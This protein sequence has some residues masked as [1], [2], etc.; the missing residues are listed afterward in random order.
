M[1]PS[2]H[3]AQSRDIRGLYDLWAPRYPP[4]PHN[5]LMRAEQRAMLAL[6]PDVTGRRVLDLACGS[7]RYAHLM[8][9]AGAGHVTAVDFSP[10]MLSRCRA[11]SPVCANM[12]DLPF[13][14]G[15]FAAVICA[16]AI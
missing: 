2:Q 16:L 8:Q 1:N 13:A 4:E 5:P 12:L 14:D 6:C 7:G 11:G 10:A 9:E 3:A 15:V